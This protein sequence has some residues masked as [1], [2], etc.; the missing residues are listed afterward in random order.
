M[1]TVSLL[2]VAILLSGCG[3]KLGEIRP[4]PMRSV[5][6]LA[7]PTFK[8]NTYEPRIEVLMADTVIKQ[9]QQDGTYTIVS[10]DTADAILYGT[11]TK[12]ERRSLRSVQNNVLATSEFGLTVT[13]SYQVVDRVTGAVLMKSVVQ[14]DT[15]FF[16]SNDLQTT[17]RQAIPLAAQRLAVDLSAALSEG[18]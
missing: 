14:G 15:S 17:E 2:L 13:V 5:R 10:D 1:R 3:Y 11:V 18:W 4:T 6:T 7:I 8:N 16:S 9:F 12:I